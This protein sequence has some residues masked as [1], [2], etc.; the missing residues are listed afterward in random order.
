MTM[1][2]IMHESS[3][4]GP[5]DFI[6]VLKDGRVVELGSRSDS[7]VVIPSYKSDQ[8]KFRKIMESQ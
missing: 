8:G 7:E 2:V 1:V 5:K 6:Y 4:I 3:Q